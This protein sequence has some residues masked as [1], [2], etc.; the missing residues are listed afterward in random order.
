[1]ADSTTTNLLLTKPEVGASTDTWGTKVNAD[2][3]T[4]DALFDTGPLLKVT[5]GGTG[6]GTSTGS[7]NNVLS[8]SPTLVTPAL[9]TPSALVGTNITGTAANFNIN[10]TVGATTATTGAFTTLAAS[11]TVT[12]S[13][14]TANGVTYLN[15]SKVLTSGSAL[16]FSGS[17]LAVTGTLSATQTI[18]S[19]LGFT[20]SGQAAAVSGSGMEI[21]GGATPDLL[22]YNRTS[23]AYLPLNMRGL[24]FTWQPS[25]TE[26]MRL[27]S[28]GLGIG[29]SSPATK[30][31]ASATSGVTELRLTNT[32][33]ASP[34]KQLSVFQGSS[35][36]VLAAWDESGVIEATSTGGLYLGAY[37]GPIRFYAG[38][39]ARTERGRFDS[40]GRLLVGLT[41]N[42]SGA[43]LQV[44]GATDTAFTALTVNAST[45]DG[46]MGIG[47][48][49]SG[50]VWQIFPTYNA[51]AGYKPLA[52]VISGSEQAR[53]PTNGGFQS[54]NSISVG[55][56]TPTT[57]G[58]GITFPATQSASTDANTLDDYEEGTWTPATST[59]G[60]TISSS[61]GEYTKIGRAVFLRFTLVFSAV[62]GSSNSTLQISGLPFTSGAQQFSGTGRECAVNGIIFVAHIPN[63]SSVT[64][65]NSY[66]GVANGSAQIFVATTSNYVFSINYYV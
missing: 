2:L 31:H 9:G 30:I 45:N 6:V 36:T 64:N 8:T 51:T 58:A 26:A 34:D 56:A 59:S 43:R 14:G 16:T 4:I 47:Y 15:G 66:S 62:N 17:A 37:N 23:S 27:D 54:V 48:S 53:F 61:S 49:S 12:L 1:M 63:S 46:Y 19:T 57:S 39:T 41:S 29:T 11:S 20:A 50:S 35:S 42:L 40:S 24:N 18:S 10:G 52:F 3:D 55:N 60:Y 22:A 7:G 28:T 13:G 25:G 32:G 65:L 5:K 44:Q 38:V 33:S 21:S